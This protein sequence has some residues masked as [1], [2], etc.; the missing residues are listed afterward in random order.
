[1]RIKKLKWDSDYFGFGIADLRLSPQDADLAQ[2]EDYARK[3][4]IK[5]IQARSDISKIESI[6]ILERAGFGFADL[7]LTYGLDLEKTKTR[8]TEIIIADKSDISALK[9]IADNIFLDSRFYHKGFDREKVKKLYMIWVESAVLGNFDDICIKAVK[10]KKITGFITAKFLR[11]GRVRVGLLGVG[12]DYQGKGIGTELVQVLAFHCK[13]NKK[14]FI[15]VSTQGKNL[16][17]SNFYIK[18][19]FR[20]KKVESWYYKFL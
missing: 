13:K 17:A 9:K 4:G 1:M 5:F 6:D 10:D 3:N 19:N 16:R 7:R 18:N 12:K 14:R 11:G 20:L 15:E 8:K 2:V